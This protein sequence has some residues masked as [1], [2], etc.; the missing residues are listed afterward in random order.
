MKPFLL[1][2][3]RKKIVFNQEKKKD[4]YCLFPS[5]FQF[6]LSL[7][8]FNLIQLKR[9]YFNHRIDEL[10]GKNLCDKFK[11]KIIIFVF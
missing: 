8:Q 10:F 3:I 4:E 9:T 1:V 11:L 2:K 7:I 6:Q 5:L